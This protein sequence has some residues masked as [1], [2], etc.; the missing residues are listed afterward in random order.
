M[1]V[2]VK[3][4]PNAKIAPK[5]VAKTDEIGEILEV[6]VREPAVEGRANKA[7]IEALASHFSVAKTRVRL[8]S[9]AKSRIKVFEV[10]D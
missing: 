9:G 6:F 8:A 5:I 7:V 2:R 10:E 3:V 1:K 4:K